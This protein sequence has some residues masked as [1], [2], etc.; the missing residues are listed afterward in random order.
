MLHIMDA[1]PHHINKTLYRT[2]AVVIEMLER[3]YIFLSAQQFAQ[4]TGDIAAPCPRCASLAR[5]DAPKETKGVIAGKMTRVKYIVCGKCGLWLCL[6][7]IED[8]GNDDHKEHA[9]RARHFERT[10]DTR[11]HV[12][13]QRV[14]KAIET[15]IRQWMADNDL[16]PTVDG[17]TG[18]DLRSLRHEALAKMYYGATEDLELVKPEIRTVGDVRRKLDSILE[19]IVTRSPAFIEQDEIAAC[20]W[21]TITRD[22]VATPMGVDSN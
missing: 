19:R 10:F 7:G 9:R 8:L 17:I 11:T 13:K 14:K 6:P 22:G 15:R 2:K 16:A 4:C 1:A 20:S 18:L 3:D 5:M 12:E 21:T